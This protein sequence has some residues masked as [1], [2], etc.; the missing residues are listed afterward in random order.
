MHTPNAIPLYTTNFIFRHTTP[1]HAKPS[2]L[3]PQTRESWDPVVTMDFLATVMDVLDVQ[4]PAA[5]VCQQ[6]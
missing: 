5:Q 3:H 1:I 4:R 6:R 2:A